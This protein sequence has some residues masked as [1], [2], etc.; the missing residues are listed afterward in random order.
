M[1]SFIAK[2]SCSQFDQGNVILLVVKSIAYQQPGGGGGSQGKLGWSRVRVRVRV[3]PCVRPKLPIFSPTGTFFTTLIRF[4]L[5]TLFSSFQTNIFWKKIIGATNVDRSS[6]TFTFLLPTQKDTLFKILNSEIVDPENHTYP[7][8]L[9]IPG[10]RL[11]P[12]KE[13][14]SPLGI[15]KPLKRICSHNCHA[16]TIILAL[17][18]MFF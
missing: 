8:Q 12:I 13:C 6:P 5:P 14:P 9:H 2:S 7:V 4:V 17:R 10:T 16:L 18:F 1:P 3:R 15:H 11:G